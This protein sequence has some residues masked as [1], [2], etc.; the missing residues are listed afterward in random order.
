MCVRIVWLALLV[1]LSTCAP[2]PSHAMSLLP[3]PTT[4]PKAVGGMGRPFEE[5]PPLDG[6]GAEEER[7]EAA[8]TPAAD[9]LQSLGRAYV[10]SMPNRRWHMKQIF[11]LIGVEGATFVDPVDRAKLDLDALRREGRLLPPDQLAE[12]LSA[13]DVATV[14]SHSK[15]MRMF[16][17]STAPAAASSAFADKASGGGSGG[18]ARRSGTRGEVMLLFEDDIDE[19]GLP[20]L[21]VLQKQFREAVAALGTPDDWDVLFLG[22][23]WDHCWLD[24]VVRPGALVRCHNPSCMHAV[25]LTRRAAE[26]YLSVPALYAAADDQLNDLIRD[27]TLRAYAIKPGLFHQDNFKFGKSTSSQHRPP[28][29]RDCKHDLRGRWFVAIFGVCA[30][31]L[32][33][34]LNLGVSCPR[35]VWRVMAPLLGY[36][37]FDHVELIGGAKG[38]PW[39]ASRLVLRTMGLIVVPLWLSI[40]MAYGRGNLWIFRQW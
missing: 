10:V 34:A 20:A 32:T 39:R 3:P 13:G 40:W 22:R 33:L 2:A 6:G 14:L 11:R 23:C 15:A 31:L 9:W 1:P 38:S 21:P 16:L 7:E 18:A 19:A 25:A 30:L 12:P 5:A 28:L 35:A 27:G 17:D 26:A 24:E 4:E 8:D 36:A 29:T 37:D